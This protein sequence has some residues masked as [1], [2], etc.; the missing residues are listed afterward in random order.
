MQSYYVTYE[1]SYF[2]GANKPVFPFVPLS[3]IGQVQLHPRLSRV[4]YLSGSEDMTQN[5]RQIIEV[6][7]KAMKRRD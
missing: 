4:Q 5:V 1:W 7:N 3:E 2:I 6:M